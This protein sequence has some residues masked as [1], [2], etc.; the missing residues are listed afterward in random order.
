MSLKGA[1]ALL[2]QNSKTSQKYRCGAGL[3][4]LAMCYG[5]KNNSERKRER[6]RTFSFIV[7][8]CYALAPQAKRVTREADRRDHTSL[9]ESR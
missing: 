5:H 6:H 4:G 3:G 7:L 1:C 2:V 8:L 9:V